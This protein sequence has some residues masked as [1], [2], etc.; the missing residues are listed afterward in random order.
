M[1]IVSNIALITI[2]WTLFHQLIAFL[3][4]MFIMNRI[5]FR[6][7]QRVMDERDNL[8]ERINQET[9]DTAKELE[10]LTDE[11]QARESAVRG[12]SLG[13]RRRLEEKGSNEAA[14]ILESTRQ[15][16][17]SMKEKAEIEID[18]KISDA[19]KHLQKESEALMVNIM[20]KLLDRRL[21]P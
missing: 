6:P 12:E 1:E 16:I 5:M 9:I 4:F 2:N 21:T 7:I 10:R 15:K 11:L 13:V 14:E 8:I 3:I 17:K 19:K 20:E 18:A